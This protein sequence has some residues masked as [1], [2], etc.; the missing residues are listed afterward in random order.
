MLLGGMPAWG[1]ER[2]EVSEFETVVVTATKT[3][4]KLDNVPAVVT[5][6]ER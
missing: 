4:K 6:I 5:V 1:T 3:P 2:E